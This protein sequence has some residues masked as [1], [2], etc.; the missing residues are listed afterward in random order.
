[1][2]MLAS[3][4]ARHAPHIA[5]GTSK[6]ELVTTKTIGEQGLGASPRTHNP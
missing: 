5:K 3:S 6:R 1:M 2:M 4:G